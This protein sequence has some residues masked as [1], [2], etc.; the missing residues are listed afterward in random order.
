MRTVSRLLP[1]LLLLLFAADCERRH[2]RLF[3]SLDSGT[4][5]TNQFVNLLFL[6]ATVAEPPETNLN[7]DEFPPH[8]GAK[9]VFDDGG[10]MTISFTVPV[11]NVSGYFTYATR[12]TITAFDTSNNLIGSISSLFESN[13]GLSGDLG[14]QPNELLSFSFLPGLSRIVIT[15]GSGW[16]VV[17]SG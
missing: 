14:S 11:T 9:V 1:L 8:S 5:I 12:V 15:R 3:E 17:Y 10:P 7:E 13:L 4:V 6:N 16:N 2:D